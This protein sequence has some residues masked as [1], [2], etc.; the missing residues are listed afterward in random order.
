MTELM[1]ANR[2]EEWLDL[3]H[4]LSLLALVA[5]AEAGTGNEIPV[6]A[7][8]TDALGRLIAVT[9]NQCL[10][11]SDPIGHAEMRAMRLGAARTDNY[12]LTHAQ[13][14]VTL[15]PCPMCLAA[16]VLARLDRVQFAARRDTTPLV[17]TKQT[18]LVAHNPRHDNEAVTLL[19]FFFALKR[20]PL[21]PGEQSALMSPSNV[22]HDWIRH[23]DPHTK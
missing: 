4:A 18:R 17:T 7:A 11:G 10:T 19:R 23:M 3:D 16:M 2:S 6:G 5:G 15:E 20:N 22:D 14:T 1:V 13:L 8:L 12:R 21:H 9:G